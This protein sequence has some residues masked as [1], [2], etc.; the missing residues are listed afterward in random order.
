MNSPS[1]QNSG[2]SDQESIRLRRMQ[3]MLGVWKTF[4]VNGWF[5]EDRLK[6]SV[7]LA[8]E[9]VE[10]YLRDREVM[11]IRYQIPGRIQLYKIAGL[12]TASI[13][14]YRPITP[15][16]DE[17]QPGKEFYANELLA[18]YHA[19]AI[20]A[21]HSDAGFRLSFLDQDWFRKWRDEMI[22]FLHYRNYSP[23]GLCAIFM[24]LSCLLFPDNLASEND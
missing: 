13:M 19:L 23:E 24:T 16:V 18:I 21:E 11:K 17:L 14:R 3:T 4:L 1:I 10:H 6:V 8:N 5:K 2:E 20:C 15:L 7:H 9:V 22:Y 12:M